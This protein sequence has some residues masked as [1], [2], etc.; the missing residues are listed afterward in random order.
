MKRLSFR[1]VLLVTFLFFCLILIPPVYI[2]YEILSN[3]QRSEILAPKITDT[4]LRQTFDKFVDHLG[5]PIT[6]KEF[7]VVRDKKDIFFK[8]RYS[9]KIS[10]KLGTYQLFLFDWEQSLSSK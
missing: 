4:E 9:E 6:V 10:L 2:R 8:I 5:Q 3:L 7:V 1:L